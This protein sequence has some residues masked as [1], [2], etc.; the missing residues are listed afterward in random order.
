MDE[1]KEIRNQNDYTAYLDPY[2]PGPITDWNI[3]PM[4]IITVED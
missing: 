2:F 1:R 3:K 4:S